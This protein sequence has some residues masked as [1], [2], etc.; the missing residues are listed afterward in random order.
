MVGLEGATRKAKEYLETAGYPGLLLRLKAVEQS[1]Y[2]TR[3]R[4]VFEHIFEPGQALHIEVDAETGAVTAFR[5]E[6]NG[7]R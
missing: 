3:W 7:G 1:G 6:R 5:R 4:F 2:P